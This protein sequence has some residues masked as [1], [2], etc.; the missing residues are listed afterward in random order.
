MVNI[1]KAE[2]KLVRKYFPYV[3]IKRTV[4]RYYM[5]ENRKA[6]EFLKNYNTSKE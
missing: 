5:E 6:M 4:H 2:A 3:H 1:S